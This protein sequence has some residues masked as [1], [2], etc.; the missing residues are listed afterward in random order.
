MNTRLA[1]LVSSILFLLAMGSALAQDLNRK[2][3]NGLKQGNWKKLY[4][5][6][7]TRY[8]GQFKN[9]KPVGLF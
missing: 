3:E 5:N 7:K 4:K 6:G 9:D 2:D 8:E 1:F